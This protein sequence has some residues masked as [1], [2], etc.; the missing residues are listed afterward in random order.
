MIQFHHGI[1]H[2]LKCYILL[3]FYLPV[4]LWGL[5]VSKDDHLSLGQA[6]GDLVVTSAVLAS[7]L[8]PNLFFFTGY[9]ASIPIISRVINALV[10]Y[11]AL[12]SLLV[13]EYP[14]AVM[15]VC[16][17][18]SVHILWSVALHLKGTRSRSLVMGGLVCSS[19]KVFCAL[20]PWAHYISGPP[21]ML[22]ARDVIFVAMSTEIIGM[23]LNLLNAV[24]LG[25]S[26]DL[27]F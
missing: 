8:L 20:I 25:V 17:F 1:P 18:G 27:F 10:C 4:H 3:V 14:S 15:I 22:Q 7:L 5:E 26:K 24:S 16:C 2:L 12:T 6:Y 21:L 9:V 19:C 23:G 13:L 11:L